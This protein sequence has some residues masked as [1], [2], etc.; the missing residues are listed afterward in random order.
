MK[1]LITYSTFSDNTS[2]KAEVLN[3]SPFISTY[4]EVYFRTLHILGRTILTNRTF[5][6]IAIK[7]AQITMLLSPLFRKNIFMNRERS[8]P[9]RSN[10]NQVKENFQ[11]FR[12]TAQLFRGSSRLFRGAAQ[13]FRGSAQLFRGG[14]HL[15]RRT[16]HLFRGSS[17]LFRGGSHLF[18]RTAQ[19]FRGGSQLFRGTA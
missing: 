16:A 4:P 3:P 12:G 11:L 5:P 14:S 18:R 9:E 7:D 1:A 17:H 6:S 15:F 19:L 8:K 13:L 2:T 10:F